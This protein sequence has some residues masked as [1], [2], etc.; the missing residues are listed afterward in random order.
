MVAGDFSIQKDSPALKLGIE[1]LPSDFLSRVGP[2]NDPFSKR[3]KSLKQELL[4][5]E[6]LQN[7]TPGYVAN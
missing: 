5:P 1:S 7:E 2:A 4:Y 6:S 3:F